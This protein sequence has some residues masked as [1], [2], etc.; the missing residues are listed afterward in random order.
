MKGVGNTTRHQLAEACTR[1]GAAGPLSPGM[2]DQAQLGRRRRRQGQGQGHMCMYMFFAGT[3]LSPVRDPL[4]LCSFIAP[5]NAKAT[6]PPGQGGHQ[7]Q[8]TR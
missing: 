7:A 4:G 6:L 3:L 1:L 2:L 8:A 5:R